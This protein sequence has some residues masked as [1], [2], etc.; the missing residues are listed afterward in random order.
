MA[1][2]ESKPAPLHV[3]PNDSVLKRVPPL[4]AEEARAVQLETADAKSVAETKQLSS[5][6]SAEQIKHRAL[7]NEATRTEAFR[8]HFERLSLFTLYVVWG[9]IILIGIFWAYHMIAPTAWHFLTSDQKGALQSL[10]TGGVIA[11]IASGHTK[12]RLAGGQ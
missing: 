3:V 4:P 8:D 6:L 12:R 9:V 2:D 1:N 5:D 11:G 10:L 7:N